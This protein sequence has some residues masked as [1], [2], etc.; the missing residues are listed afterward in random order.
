VV[1]AGNGSNVDCWRELD[2][3]GVTYMG[4]VGI[5]GGQAVSTQLPTWNLK[6][7]VEGRGR[8]P[9]RWYLPA[10]GAPR[11]AVK[12]LAETLE[13]TPFGWR[14]AVSDRCRP[15]SPESTSG[16]RTAGAWAAGLTTCRTLVPMHA[17][18][19]RNGGAM[20]R[21][22]IRCPLASDGHTGGAVG[23]WKSAGRSSK[24]TS[25]SRR[26]SGSIISVV[27]PGQDPTT[28]R[29]YVS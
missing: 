22:E 14:Q 11:V 19:S 1:D 16:R 6:P 25:S 27:A 17:G 9:E 18:C 3:R 29:R 12:R 5:V 15:S 20:A 2:E 13:R 24:G 28:M 8:P 26:N 21:S 4:W 10:D 23:V 7:E